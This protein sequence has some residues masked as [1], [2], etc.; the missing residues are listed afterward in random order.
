MDYGGLIRDAWAMTWRYRFLWVLGLFA[1]GAIG[2]G[3]SGGGGSSVQWQVA[4][5]DIERLPPAV[6]S[7]AQEAGRWA[8]ANVG[9]I[10]LVAA[11][12][13]LLVIALIVV[14]VIAQGEMARATADLAD[15]RPTTLGRAWATGLRLFWRY[16]GLWLL[17]IAATI[18]VAALVAAIAVLG[19]VAL[20]APM[21]AFEA[22]RFLL[23]AILGLAI[24][25][26]VVAAI[27]AGVS[28]SIVVTFAQRA[29]AVDDVGPVDALREG[30]ALFRT[31]LGTSL[32]AWLVN[33]ALAIGGGI[34]VGLAM[35]AVGLVLGAVGAALWSAL[36]WA[37]PTIGYAGLAAILFLA[38]L[39]V[40]VGIFNTFFWN[41][42]TLVYLRMGGPRRG[43]AAPA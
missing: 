25:S 34:A 26:L 9:A 42:W 38:V 41:Y 13:A 40:A 21:Q 23:G 12:V 32:L 39:L 29:I 22:P 10:V 16:V 1:G 4:P 36:G 20:F 28:A 17:L 24:L 2:H 27:V 35:A 18:L 3:S 5:G 37:L 11:L 19:A 43:V 14:S 6:G 15:G 31:H 8:A 30:W 7:A 33:V